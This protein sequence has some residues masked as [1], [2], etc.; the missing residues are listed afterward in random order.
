MSNSFL[1]PWIVACQAPL[2]MGFP[3]QKYW[4]GLP[5]PSPKQ[6]SDPGIEPMFPAWLTDS[7]PLSH[8]R[9]PLRC[10]YFYICMLNRSENNQ[11]MDKL[12][13]I[14]FVKMTGIHKCCH[15]HLNVLSNYITV[16]VIQT[17]ST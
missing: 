1:T 16:V 4:S 3:R 15:L 12:R 17:E 2:S 6:I 5:F 13:K 7:L 11:S 9:N 10:Y 8:Q 14:M